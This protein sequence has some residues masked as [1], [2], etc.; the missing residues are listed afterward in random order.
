MKKKIQPPAAFVQYLDGLVDN[1][2]LDKDG[3]CYKRHERRSIHTI[4]LLENTFTVMEQ[5][6]MRPSEWYQSEYVYSDASM[7]MLKTVFG[8]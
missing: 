2:L 3:S 1:N 4:T 8:A 5:Q 7:N 6:R